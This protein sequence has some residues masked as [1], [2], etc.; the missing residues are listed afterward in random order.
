MVCWFLPFYVDQIE[1]LT[2]NIKIRNGESH[3]KSDE[4]AN[5]VAL[6]RYLIAIK[7]ELARAQRW[8]QIDYK[9]KIDPQYNDFEDYRKKTG[10]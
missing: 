2:T 4:P 9:Y 10:H 1:R 7:S 8:P 3:K 6:G 5:E